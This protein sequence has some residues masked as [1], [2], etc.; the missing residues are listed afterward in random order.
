MNYPKT[1]TLLL[2]MAAF[3]TAAAQEAE[4][5]EA[6]DEGAQAGQ[7]AARGP[8]ELDTIVVSA[9]K[10]DEPVEK[11]PG[12]V[13]TWS[14]DDLL[15][16]QLSGIDGLSS[17][18][19]TMQSAGGIGSVHVRGMGGGGRNT[20][21]DPRVPVYVDGIYAGGST[22]LLAPLANFDRAQLLRGSQG[23][24]F[25]RNAIAG[26]ILVESRDP[27]SGAQVRVVDH[28]AGGSASAFGGWERGETAIGGGAGYLQRNTRKSS[29]LGLSLRSEV[30]GGELRVGLDQAQVDDQSGRGQARS[31]FFGVPMATETEGNSSFNATVGGGS[32]R[33]GREIGKGSLEVVAGHRHSYLQRVFDP[34]HLPQ[35]LLM[36]DYR[37]RFSNSSLEAR[38]RQPVGRASVMVGAYLAHEQTRTKRLATVGTDTG[39]LIY[40][41]GMGLIPYGPLFGVVPGVGATSDGTVSTDVRAVFGAAD[42]PVGERLAIQISGRVENER[43]S[44]QFD[45]D[46]SRS[47]RLGLATI[48]GFSDETSGTTFSPA[49][50]ATWQTEAGMFFGKASRAYKSGGWNLDFLN[51]AQV[52]A[53]IDF[54]RERMD[55]VEVGFKSSGRTLAWDVVAF[56]STAHDYQVFQAVPLESGGAVFVL[57]N[58]AQ[59]TSVGV[60]GQLRWKGENGWH[61]RVGAAWNR[62]RFD[63]FPEGGRAGEDLA[64]NVMPHAPQWS[65]NIEVGREWETAGAYWR[66]VSDVEAYSSSYSDPENTPAQRLDPGASWNARLERE[67]L[68][69]K[70]TV[71]AFARNILDD[72]SDS[73]HVTDFFGHDVYTRKEGRVVGIEAAYRW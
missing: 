23:P 68:D 70:L 29:S 34:D 7:E 5:E 44:A 10:L 13:T 16:D 59:A 3:A 9:R 50:G 20:G 40:V 55:T 25:G 64:G 46:G 60:E 49:V 71:A 41:P 19:M 67:S 37:D 53:G 69:G 28:S 52:A 1:A 31:G 27:A 66:A 54:D 30:A 17:H 11:V 32:A 56:H 48:Q 39:T 15:D 58:A 14:Q 38:W 73:H 47:G 8:V 4:V 24:L 42:I 62:A 63:S 61:A 65:G 43:R 26:A 33:W 45:L 21:F 6:Q 51:R 12:S 22:V 2:L 72:R 36:A 35:D 18:G 57:D